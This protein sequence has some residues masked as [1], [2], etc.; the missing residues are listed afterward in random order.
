MAENTPHTA[1][2]GFYLA[3]V[4]RYDVAG[5]LHMFTLYLINRLPE[6]VHYDFDLEKNRE[7]HEGFEGHVSAGDTIVITDLDFMELDRQPVVNLKCR[8]RWQGK[9]EFFEK[10]IRPKPKNLLQLKHNEWLDAPAYQYEL[11]VPKTANNA[12][13]AAPKK[14]AVDTELLRMYM[15]QNGRAPEKVSISSTSFE[16]DLHFEAIMPDDGSLSAG[17]KFHVQL[18][19]F[20]KQLDLAIANGLHYMVF[21][22]GVG[23]GKLK[24]E[25]YNLLQKHPHVRSYGPCLAPK[26]GFGATE[27]FF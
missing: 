11:W 21:I 22:H 24:K 26:Y 9:T 1:Q 15:L 3:F 7:W 19:T 18:E 4:P 10:S 25:L 27:V 12:P 14:L 13:P 5:T 2:Q 23:S 6:D 16:V 17:A 20:Q 8:V